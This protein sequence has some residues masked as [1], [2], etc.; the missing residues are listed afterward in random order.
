MPLGKRFSRQRAQASRVVVDWWAKRPSPTPRLV[1]PRLRKTVTNRFSLPRP[2]MTASKRKST[3]KCKCSFGGE[4]GI[5]FSRELRARSS[6]VADVH[7]K[8]ALYRFPFE[9]LY[10]KRSLNQ[11]TRVRFGLLFGGEEGIR[12]LV[13]LG[14]RFSRPPRYDHFDTSP[15]MLKLG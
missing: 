14:K 7:R 1:A 9:S 15:Y 8:S 6:S 13:P 10:T 11:T 5:R 2:V 3:C 12:T 4:E